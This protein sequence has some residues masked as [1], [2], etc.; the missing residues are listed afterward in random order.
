MLRYED[1]P[2]SSITFDITMTVL[3]VIYTI[4]ILANNKYKNDEGIS[5]RHELKSKKSKLDTFLAISN[6]IIISICNNKYLIALMGITAFCF[7]IIIRSYSWVK[8]DTSDE[9][10][11]L[12]DKIDENKKLYI[13]ADNANKELIKKIRLLESEVNISKREIDVLNKENSYLK[14]ELDI[15]K[16]G[17]EIF[18]C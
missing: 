7:I 16:S 10:S 6:I 1:L 18:E 17:K 3:F 8:T 12:Y 11:E 13:D 2:I 15:Y 4:C 14:E 9:N 5:E